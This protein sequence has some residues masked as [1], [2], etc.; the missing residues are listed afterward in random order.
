MLYKYKM[1]NDIAEGMFANEIEEKAKL[2]KVEA[3]IKSLEGSN[4]YKQAKG[5]VDRLRQEI[6]QVEGDLELLAQEDE[7]EARQFLLEKVKRL[8]KEQLRI[9]KQITAIQS[10]IDSL[11]DEQSRMQSQLAIKT[12]EPKEGPTE[13]DLLHSKFNEQQQFLADS[14]NVKTHLQLERKRLNDVI[15]SLQQDLEKKRTLMLPSQEEL[16]LMKREVDFTSK[17][18][19]NNKQTICRLQNQK[20]KR[21]MELEKI[22]SLED[23]IHSELKEIYA[24]TNTMKEEM[25]RFK[26]A[27]DLQALADETRDTLVELTE[28]CAQK[29]DALEVQL[30]EVKIES[31]HMAQTLEKNPNWK[32]IEQ[33]KTK[34]RENETEISALQKDVDKMEA[35]GYGEKKAKCLSLVSKINEMNISKQWAKN[36][37]LTR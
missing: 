19:D 32:T 24:K 3:Q 15:V 29:I 35:D 12:Y 28:V 13:I 9:D 33:L 25:S 5:R 11:L 2:A 8:D 20:H 10:E 31:E 18:L 26:S 7:H 22:I 30:K 23:K 17:H 16:V 34:M 37:A 21:E 1:I 36:Q 6:A 27:K 14:A 4:P